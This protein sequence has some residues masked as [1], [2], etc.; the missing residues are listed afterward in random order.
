MQHPKGLGGGEWGQEPDLA[1][2]N[3]NDAGMTVHT[4]RYPQ[5]LL[6]VL[7]AWR[8]GGWG[9]GHKLCILEERLGQP[10]PALD[11]ACS[12]LIGL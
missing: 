1:V 11:S 5:G 4:L 8:S 6:S 7:K 2:I 12:S 3:L 10:L 9:D